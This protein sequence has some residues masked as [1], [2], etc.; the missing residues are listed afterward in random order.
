MGRNFP[1]RIASRV[2]WQLAGRILRDRQPL[3]HSAALRMPRCGTELGAAMQTAAKSW[4]IF[5]A[6]I[7]TLATS[8]VRA[9]TIDIS[10][11]RGGFV[12]IYLMKWQKLA[13]QHPNVRITGV[14]LSACTGL[15]GYIPRKNICMTDK[16]VLGFHLATMSFATRQLLEV[17]PDDIKAWIDKHGGLTY[18]VMWMQAP[19]TYH[20]FKKCPTG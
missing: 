15:L 14:C 9:E 12:F 2:V 16:G 20:Y 11:D 1:N 17:Y 5:L 8:A 10:E 3:E 13:A 7:F 4:R 19:E 18:Q 6:V